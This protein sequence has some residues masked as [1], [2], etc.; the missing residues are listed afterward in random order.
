MNT[1]EITQITQDV[2]EILG[3]HT[4]DRITFKRCKRKWYFSSPLRLH[5][6]A[7]GNVSTPL[8]FG[9][10]FHF[11]LEDFHGFRLWP[12][13]GDAFAAYAH[14][15]LDDA[16]P[17]DSEELIVL[18][19]EMLE[20]YTDWCEM[21]HDFTTYI[22]EYDNIA[23]LGCE[24]DFAI[25]LPELKEY[26][27]NA[28]YLGTLDGIFIGTDGLYWIAEY[29]TAAMFDIV[30]LATDDQ[31]TAYLW[32]LSKCFPVEQIGG[33]VYR[34]F[35]K[36]APVLPTVLQNGGLSQ[37]K[38]QKTTY[39]KYHRMMQEIHPDKSLSSLMSVYQDI[40]RHLGSKEAVTGDDF[41][42]QQ[43]VRRSPHSLRSQHQKILVDSLEM[44]TAPDAFRTTNPT[45]DCAWD[46]PYRELCL[47]MD[48][49]LDIQALI[50]QG[51]GKHSECSEL[52]KTRL[53][54]P[55]SAAK[56]GYNL[57][58][59]VG[60]TWKTFKDERQLIIRG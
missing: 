20:H 54:I 13:P 19:S 51:Y 43:L 52:W 16:R 26:N 15:C 48:E 41:L 40:L 12:T 44:I 22:P 47:A 37:N 4:S 34:Q 31:V 8:W 50:A 14:A 28:Q 24:V 60:K 10:G 7:K 27:I 30:K 57:A 5:L 42:S 3:I 45:R 23:R 1:Q 49:G 21:F 6:S 35:K 36:K 39:F 46:C 11:A 56:R 2:P 38:A 29:K 59:D 9:T 55:E 17:H 32:A 53:K 25:E 58:N 18:A 33:M